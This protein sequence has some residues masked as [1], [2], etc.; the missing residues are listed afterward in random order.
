MIGKHIAH[1]EVSARLGAGGMGEVYLARDTTLGR[2]VALK[3]LPVEMSADENARARLL[4]EARTASSLNHPHIC[5]IFEVGEAEGRAYIAMEH[6]QGEA[7]AAKIPEGGLPA[8]TVLRYGTQVAD[9]LA[10]AHE[11]G[12]IHR[13]LKTSNVVITPEGHAKVLD[14]GLAKQLRDVEM[15]EATK[16]QVSLTQSGA[17]VGTLHAI[18]PEVLSGQ[19]ADAR[20]DI[21]AL[22]VLLYE[23]AAGALPFQGKT[24]FELTS[25]ILREPPR[26]LPARVSAGL[27]AVIQRCLA[28]EPGQRYQR[29]GE[30]R[31]ALEAMGSDA[32]VAAEGTTHSA[33]RR[34]WVWILVGPA[35][36]ALA[37]LIST[38]L[39]KP[40]TPSVAPVSA[41]SGPRLS[42]GGKPSSNAEANEAFERALLFLIT[43]LN[44][45]RARQ[46]L[47]KALALDPHFAEARGW[48]GFTHL[49]MIDS[50]TSNDV[51]WLYKS[52]EELKRALQD[53]PESARAHSALG[54]V[55][56][57]GGK[58]D[59]LWKESEKA[60][61]INPNELDADN[62]LISAEQMGGDTQ[63]AKVRAQ[64]L[65][66]RAPLY[67]P[68]RMNLA[69]VFRDEGNYDAAFR[70]LGKILEQDKQNVYALVCL[71]RAR[72]EAGQLR[73][74]RAT[75]SQVN[76][77]DR[78]NY[79]VR[80]VTALLLALEGKRAEALKAM[81]SE[82]Q[83]YGEIIPTYISMVAE[84]YAVL[85]DTGKALD[86][87]DRALRNGDERAE[88]FQRNPHFASLRKQAR[89]QQILQSI[90]FRRQQRH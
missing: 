82:T 32:G 83:K 89:F 11:R 51:A 29:A 71:T 33:L 46:M 38:V 20:G 56:F 16:S 30:V 67:F 23:M 60:L 25:A 61:Q 69:D 22:G 57:Y 24:G 1:Y 68:A 50:G 6:V 73:E 27:R 36:V 59:L 37:L 87:L 79:S 74:A 21:W 42:T 58:S 43:Q 39:K 10:H 7:L 2:E 47:E 65:L 12:I 44:L 62:W 66:A 53:D 76:S 49:L 28:K 55:Y 18:A 8:D 40:N 5:T 80:L 19:P 64:R 81:D 26:A 84:F 88:W 14:F 3:L 86:A 31:A 78:Q 34:K 41:P 72:A 4:N 90:A 35:V 9:A 54:A 17:I 63:A 48:Y 52:E 13:D 77:E 70:E 75:L 85:G 45:P 15:A